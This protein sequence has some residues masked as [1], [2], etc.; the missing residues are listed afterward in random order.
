MKRQSDANV[1]TLSRTCHKSPGIHRAVFWS[2][3]PGRMACSWL[4]LCRVCVCEILTVTVVFSSEKEERNK[5]NH[6]RS[7]VPAKQFKCNGVASSLPNVL[8]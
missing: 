3:I 1:K 8:M 6:S 5:I 7:T 2:D 4:F